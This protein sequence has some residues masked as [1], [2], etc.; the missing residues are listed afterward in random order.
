MDSDPNRFHYSPNKERPAITAWAEQ[1]ERYK[2]DDDNSIE[3][4]AD[5]GRS[6]GS[7]RRDNEPEEPPP[8]DEEVEPDGS[9]RPE[10]LDIAHPWDTPQPV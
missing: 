6:S 2:R 5:S 8:S 1:D 10:E 4:S 3:D 7:D 9:P